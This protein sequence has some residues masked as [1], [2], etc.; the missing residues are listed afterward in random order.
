M[1]SIQKEVL[2]LYVSNEALRFKIMQFTIALKKMKYLG[3]NI[4][5]FAGHVH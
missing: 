2:L 5:T 3:V 1:I 4:I